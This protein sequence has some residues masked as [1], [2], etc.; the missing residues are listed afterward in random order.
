MEV[1]E[2]YSENE[3]MAHEAELS[4]LIDECDYTDDEDNDDSIL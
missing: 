3:S 4:R 2:H 1:E